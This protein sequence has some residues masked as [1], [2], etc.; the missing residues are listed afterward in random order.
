MKKT[1][2]L[3]CSCFSIIFLLISVLSFNGIKSVTENDIGNYV[4][5]DCESVSDFIEDNVTA[6][7][8]E[9]NS[10]TDEKWC[11]TTVESRKP[12]IN[13]TDNTSAVYLDFDGDNGYAVVGNDYDFLDFSIKGDLEYLKDL[14]IILFSEYDGFVYQTEYGFAR[15]DVTYA[16]EEY[17]NNVAIGRYYAGQKDY[18]G[19]GSGFITE[20]DKY[21][22]DRYGSDYTLETSKRLWGYADVKQNKYSIYWKDDHGEGNCTLSAMFGIMRYMRDYKGMNQLPRTDTI[23]KAENDSFYR[24]LLNQGYY[25]NESK[26]TVPSIYET[27]RNKSI[28][29]G[30]QADSNFW[31]SANMANIYNDVMDTYGLVLTWSFESQVKK[32]IDAGYPTMWNTARGQYGAHSMVVK[33]YKRYYKDCSIWFIKWKE[34]KSL[35]TLNDNW[36]DGDMYFDLDAYGSNIFNEGFGT[37]LRVREY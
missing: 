33:G 11:A 23:I 29:Y 37:F 27:I 26:K 24:E 25:V 3:R 1:V 32:E 16:D 17:W 22:K 36:N 31:I 4:A 30:Y 10:N 21:I 8:S 35:M 28:Y 20:P 18:K 7:V 12:V 15:F 19:E 5:K 34:Y 14:D 6:F 2:K 9:F 13:V